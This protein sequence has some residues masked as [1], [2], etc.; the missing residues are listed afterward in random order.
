MNHFSPKGLAYRVRKE[1]RCICA[2]Y[3]EFYFSQRQNLY[4]FVDNYRMIN[5]D[6]EIVIDGYPCSAN[7]F[8]EKAFRM[9]QPREVKM[10]HHTHDPSQLITAIKANIPTIALIRNPEDVTLS[11]TSRFCDPANTSEDNV[12]QL[13]HYLLN[14]YLDFYRRIIKY[15][16]Y[17]IIAEFKTITSAYDLII[18]ELNSKYEVNFNPFYCNEPNLE[19]VFLVI[20]QCNQERLGSFDENIVARPSST[21]TETKEYFRTYLNR[22]KINKMLNLSYNLYYEITS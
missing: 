12:A 13:I 14:D 16:G 7:T 20:D 19:E 15:K 22:P 6:T 18:K 10:A 1:L 9:A 2:K 21:R 17:Y 8:A 3:P 4:G 5:S 11:Y